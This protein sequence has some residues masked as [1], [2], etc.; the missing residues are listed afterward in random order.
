MGGENDFNV[1][2]AVYD[3]AHLELWFLK[4]L[5]LAMKFK[6]L[7]HHLFLNIREVRFYLKSG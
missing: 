7:K 2:L 5:L 1:H 6:M 3:T 4:N